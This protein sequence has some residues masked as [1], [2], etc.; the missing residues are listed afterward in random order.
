MSIQDERLYNKAMTAPRLQAL[1]PLLDQLSPE[2]VS[3]LA[4]SLKK[5]TELPEDKPKKIDWE[6]FDGILKH[7]PEGVEYQRAI[8]AEW[9]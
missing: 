7:G 4:E 1:Q 8:R 5:R 2:E 9:D 6:R 3:E